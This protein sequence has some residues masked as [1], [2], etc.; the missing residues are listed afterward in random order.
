M[1]APRSDSVR[2]DIRTILTRLADGHPFSDQEDVFD[3]G[4]VRS[5]NLLELIEH[6]EDT[7]HFRIEQRDVFDGHLKS[8]DRLVEFIASRTEVA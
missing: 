4:V 5:M 1:T 3:R 2:L 6:I 7:Y 8:V